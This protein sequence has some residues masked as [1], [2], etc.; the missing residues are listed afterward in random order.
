MK[1]MIII[2]LAAVVAAASLVACGNTNATGNNGTTRGNNGSTSGNNNPIEEIVTGAFDGVG[3]A[4]S[5]IGNGIS[6]AAGGI[7]DMFDDNHTNDS[8]A[9]RQYFL[10]KTVRIIQLSE[11]INFKKNEDCHMY[12]AV[13][14]ICADCRDI[15][16]MSLI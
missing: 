16:V 8:T 15:F 14:F 5:G 3:E 7:N 2:T 9:T 4:A 1:K 13:L 10:I 6:K 11:P 12:A